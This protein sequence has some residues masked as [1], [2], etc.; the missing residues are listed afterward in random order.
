MLSVTQFAPIDSSDLANGLAKPFERS[1][2]HVHQDFVDPNMCYV[3][4]GYPSP[5]YFAPGFFFF[6]L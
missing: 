5:F 2:A 3:P 4:N 6:F 1:A